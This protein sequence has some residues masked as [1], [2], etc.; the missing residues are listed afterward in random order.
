MRDALGLYKVGISECAL[1]R[2]RI[3]QGRLP[4]ERRPVRL[5]RAIE[6]PMGAAITIEREAHII[7]AGDRLDLPWGSEW[8]KAPMHRCSTAVEAAITLSELG[9]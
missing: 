6:I 8:F 9:L 4:I 1:W 3:V 7:L 2:R 5:M